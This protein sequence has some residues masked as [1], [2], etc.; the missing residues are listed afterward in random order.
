MSS[1]NWLRPDLPNKCKY[2]LGTPL[3]LS[4]HHHM[5]FHLQTRVGSDLLELIGN[6]PLVRLNS[7]PKSEGLECEIWGKCEF[8]N[9]G[10]SVK[11][12]VAKRMIEDAERTGRIK[13]GDTLIEP[14]SGNT[15]IGI[16]LIAAIKGY[17]CIIVMPEKISFEKEC[18][19]RGLGA[20]IV[21]TRTSANFEHPDSHLRTADALKKKLGPTAHILHQYINPSNPLTHFDQTAVEI[22]RDCAQSNGK[23]L[24]DGLVAGA[25][26]GGT[27]TGLSKK[28]KSKLPN[29]KV[30]GVDPQGSVIAHSVSEYKGYYDVEG[31]GYDF[32]PTVMENEF[33]DKWYKVGDNE[34]F[35]MTRRLIKE[36]GLL[37]GGSSGAAVV[38]AIRA[39]KEFGFGKGRRIVVILPDAIRNYMTKILSDEW[40]FSKG[41][42]DLPESLDYRSRWMKL[43]T[44]NLLRSIKRPLELDLKTRIVEALK[45]MKEEHVNQA[46]VTMTNAEKII[47]GIVDQRVYKKLMTGAVTLNDP[48]S[49]VM[50]KNFRKLYSTAQ[51]FDIGRYLMVEPYV[52]VWDKNVPLLVTQ[53]DFL[54]WTVENSS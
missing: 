38:G 8:L 34:S 30:I 2:K 6:T 16:A 15:G 54:N 29:C 37:C 50:N 41:F 53:E 7:I 13:P 22:L 26:T 10:G 9:P 14:T 24:L 31:I 33:V 51:V 52:V 21:R 36:E 44:K 23:V 46:L 5:P 28:I 35:H 40:M 19:L 47:Y 18:L 27:V 49:N 45:E 48:V 25:G 39:A 20:E 43:D 4:P 3:S 1:E 12:R 17:R 32:I 42:L 11:D